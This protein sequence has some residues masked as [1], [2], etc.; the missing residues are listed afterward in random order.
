MLTGNKD[1]WLI[2][3]CA[4]AAAVAGCKETQINKKNMCPSVTKLFL[5][6]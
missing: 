4:L 3:T 1:L 2:Q 6:S 5:E